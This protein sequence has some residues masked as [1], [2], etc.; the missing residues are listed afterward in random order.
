MLSED[1]IVARFVIEVKNETRKLSS[2]A[3]LLLKR[4]DTFHGVGLGLP[5]PEREGS[6]PAITTSRAGQA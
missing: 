2:G 4:L 6:P 1:E 5:S 3:Q